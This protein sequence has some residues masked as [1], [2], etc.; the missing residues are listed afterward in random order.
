[1]Q[2]FNMAMR[3]NL[4]VWLR[5]WRS[6]SQPVWAGL[7]IEDSSNDADSPLYEFGLAV[8]RI[9][10]ARAAIDASGIPVVLTARCEAW[11]V[12]QTDPLKVSLER[13]VI[14]RRGRSRLS[15]CAGSVQT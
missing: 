1:M 9:K 11:L 5:A 2:T 8:E 3:M 7:S 4:K 15:V 10:A 12:G 13:L 14:F 6:A